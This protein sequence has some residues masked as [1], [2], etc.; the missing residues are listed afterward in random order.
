[1]LRGNSRFAPRKVRVSSEETPSLSEQ[2]E[3]RLIRSQR[4]SAFVRF[5]FVGN[6]VINNCCLVA[7]TERGF[8]GLNAMSLVRQEIDVLVAC[9][10]MGIGNAL[11]QFNIARHFTKRFLCIGLVD[12][13]HALPTQL[14]NL[15]L[16]LFGQQRALR[17]D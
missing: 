5:V 12:N 4:K 17:N 11:R 7:H 1:M 14:G 9:S 16:D 8:D 15:R 10:A 3:N 13:L 6:S 2:D